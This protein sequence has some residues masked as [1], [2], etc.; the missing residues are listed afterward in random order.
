MLKK[1]GFETVKL[2][3]LSA[4]IILVIYGIIHFV[5]RG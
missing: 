4:I 2:L 3:S 1:L 5:L